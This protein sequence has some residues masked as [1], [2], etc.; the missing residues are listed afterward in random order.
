MAVISI[1]RSLDGV[2]TSATVAELLVYN[3]A[4]TLV[5]GPVVVTPSAAGTYSVDTTFLSPGNYTAVWEFQQTGEDDVTVR[6][7]FVVDGPAEVYAGI[8]L[9]SIEQALAARTGPYRRLRCDDGSS[10]TTVSIPRL[11]SSLTLGEHEDLY[12]LRR[13]ILT[14]GEL[15]TGFVADDRV[16]GVDT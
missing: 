1:L 10:S 12:V 9:A 16:R 6:R 3:S 11:R 5:Y 15:V 7:P 2:L 13:G 4:G 8:T 14:T